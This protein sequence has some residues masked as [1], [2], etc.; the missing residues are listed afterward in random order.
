MFLLVIMTMTPSHISAN[1][2][3]AIELPTQHLLPVSPV[4]R[5]IQDSDGYFWYATEGGGLC[6]DDGYN[7]TVFRSPF[8][9]LSSHF[10]VVGVN[11]MTSNHITCLAE[12]KKKKHIW[13]GTNQGLFYIDKTDYT[14]HHV[15]NL[16]LNKN[17]IIEIASTHDGSIWVFVTG[18][19]LRLNP[20]GEL[21]EHHAVKYQDRNLRLSQ[22]LKIRA[23]TSICYLTT[24]TFYNMISIKENS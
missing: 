16:F 10:Q 1:R 11:S 7:I 18:K 4:H 6:R 21:I 3:A 9:Q 2:M 19:I 24:I 13:Y 23:I 20:D 12:G 17:I 5:V 14:V 15:Q 8:P 22:F